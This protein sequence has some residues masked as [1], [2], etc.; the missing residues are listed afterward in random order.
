MDKY[1]DNLVS[2]GGRRHFWSVNLF[3]L[4]VEQLTRNF[5]FICDGVCIWIAVYIFIRKNLLLFLSTVSGRWT[6]GI[7]VLLLEMDTG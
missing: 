2:D 4:L 3:L 6:D 5:G 7:T 1:K